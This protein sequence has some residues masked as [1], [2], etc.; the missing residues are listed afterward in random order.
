MN[1][2]RLCGIL[3]IVVGLLLWQ[4]IPGRAGGN[5]EQLFQQGNEAYS[6]GDYEQA[7]SHYEELISSAGFSPAVLFNL[8]NSYAQAGKTGRAILN[9]ERALRLAPTDSDITGNL[10]L[11][12]KESGLFTGE[13]A[14]TDRLFHLLSLDQW[15]MLG[16]TALFCFTLLHI[17]AHKYPIGRKTRMAVSITCLLLLILAV[18]GTAIR[19]QGFKPAVVIAADARLLISPFPSATSVG[20]IQ[21]GRLVSPQKQH[22]PF[23]YVKDETNRQGWILSSALEAVVSWPT[24]KNP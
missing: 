8:A 4:S 17:A 12:R 7:I 2:Q 19:Y 1:G 9:Y 11:V 3:L 16:L 14:G 22:G 21:E 5:E 6:R 20:A 24:R 10:E 23:T 15:A 13:A 18:T